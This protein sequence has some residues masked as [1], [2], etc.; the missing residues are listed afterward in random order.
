[1]NQTENQHA[2]RPSR[3]ETRVWTNVGDAHIGFFASPDAKSP[4]RK[5]R[6]SSAPDA[7]TSRLQ[8][9]DP[10]VMSRAAR[11]AGRT[12]T[13]GR[14]Q[15]QRFAP[16]RSESWHRRHARRVTT[17]AGERVIHAPLLGRGNLA[18]VLAATAV[19]STSTCRSTTSSPRRNG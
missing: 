3:A 1:M 7:T 10:R 17:P 12:L 18:N 11:F 14:L 19:A 9:D 6:F 16:P 4:M 5:P 13:F 2:R 15:A 8:C